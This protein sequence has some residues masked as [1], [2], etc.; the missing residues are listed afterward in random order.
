MNAAT[1]TGVHGVLG[2]AGAAQL[3]SDCF[4]WHVPEQS[5]F[6]LKHSAGTNHRCEN[7]P[8]T[9]SGLFLLMKDFA[10][11]EHFND[12]LEATFASFRLFCTVES[13]I[14]GEA[15]GLTDSSKESLGIWSLL[16]FCQ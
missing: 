8:L 16:Y 15:I 9:R 11:F 13:V 10:V 2:S 14:N 6:S 7:S 4:S 1:K 3:V 5:G 12:L